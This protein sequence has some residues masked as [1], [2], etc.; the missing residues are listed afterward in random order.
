MSA[1]WHIGDTRQ[2]L[3]TL[4][5]NSVDLVL[6]SPP[7]LAL[8]SY[9]PADDP[10]KPLE[11]GSEATPGEFL[12]ALLDVVVE[13]RRVLAPHGS[14]CIEL[15]DTY[16]GSGGAGGDYGDEGWR[17]GQLTY[18]QQQMVEPKTERGPRL[19]DRRHNA[20]TGNKNRDKRPGW[21]LDKSLCLIPESF[22]WAL[23]YGRNPFT[24][25]TIE[26]WRIRNVVRWCRPNPPVGALC[27]DDQTEALTPD[28][29]RR[30]DQLSDGDLIAAYDPRTDSCRFLPA[31]FV[32]WER[33]GEPMIVVEKR[34]TSQWLTEDHRC[35]TR[36]R[37]APPHVRLARDLTNECETL[38]AAPFDDVPGP[39]PVTVERAAL[40]GWFIAEGTPHGRT[41]RIV[42]SQTANPHKVDRIRSLLDTDG[43]DYS[44]SSYIARYNGSTIVTF[45]VKGELAEWLNL[46]H[47]RLP[48]QYVT[49]WPEAQA[50]ALF[51]ALIDGD[52]H[53]RKNAE[54]VLF[55]QQDE[56]VADAMQVLATRLGF[57]ASKRWQPTL[58]LWQVTMSAGTRW[59]K[60]RQWEGEGIR[61][62][63]YTGVVWCPMVETSFWLAR[64]NGRTFITGNSDKFRPATS[65]MVI[66][67]TGRNRY[68]DLDAVRTAHDVASVTRSQSNAPRRMTSRATAC[69]DNGENPDGSAPTLNPAGAPPLD[70]WRIPTQP[71]RGAH[72]ATWPEAL[73]I[74][75]IEAMCPRKVCLACNTPFERIVKSTAM[76]DGKPLESSVNASGRGGSAAH[77]FDHNR[78]STERETLGW[79]CGCSVREIAE[80]RGRETDWRPGVV[81]DPFAGTGTTGAVAIGHGRHFIGIDLDP[82]N[83]H[84]ARER[85]GMFLQL[86]EAV[87]A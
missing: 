82:R 70:W 8:R 3:A 67:C 68:F 12:D 85:I 16:A 30:H 39:A 55:H 54:G 78:L 28:G 75:P 65:E 60:L 45:T 66:A 20:T 69:P 23:A 63:L 40:L 11:M 76:L 33:E 4:P 7:F 80:G 49:T 42:Q 83:Y 46:H 41:A 47:K 29:W 86:A 22:R 13:C 35:W 18:R 87:P 34:K 51:D 71:Y 62:E 38:L 5:D 58:R 2:V 64:R 81:L 1:T 17:A 74:T 6:T 50:R 9:L 56:A 84:L 57:L 77:G 52:G 59:H 14:L 24:G 15:G 37:K 61:R 53:R 79:A 43:A 26:P 32:R 27:V 21:P 10:N 73:C 25:R 36:T 44:E 72:Y 48:M 31:K 19:Q